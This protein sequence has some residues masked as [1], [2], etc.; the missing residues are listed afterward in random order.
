[1]SEDQYL[2]FK[3]TLRDAIKSDGI[4]PADIRL[5]GSS[6]HFFSGH[7]KKM[8][9]GY[10]SIEREV[11][12]KEFWKEKGHRPTGAELDQIVAK[13]EAQWP[14]TL[15]QRPRRRPFDVMYCV[16]VSDN[17]SD[18]DVQI[19]SHEVWRRACEMISESGVPPTAA[20]VEHETYAFIDKQLFHDACP[21]IDAW[22]LLQSKTL[23]REVT[24]AAFPAQGPNDHSDTIGELSSHFRDSDWIV[25]V[26]EVTAS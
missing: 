3:S 11:V 16:G 25:N 1:M 21:A 20:L 6:A 18:Y 12:F 26:D 15:V 2:A 8:P 14:N 10:Y 4:D 17:K 22:R 24:V 13:F 19:S 23:G 7:H 5:K 9:F